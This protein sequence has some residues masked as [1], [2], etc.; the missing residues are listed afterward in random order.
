MCPTLKEINNYD[1]KESYTHIP[2]GTSIYMRTHKQMVTYAYNPALYHNFQ[3]IGSILLY[4]PINR[5]N[6]SGLDIT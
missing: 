3:I 2:R 5:L 6:Q 1:I 4:I